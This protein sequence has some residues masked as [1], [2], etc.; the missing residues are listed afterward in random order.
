MVAAR[1]FELGAS[2]RLLDVGA[3]SGATQTRVYNTYFTGQQAL[4]AHEYEKALTR[5]HI[6]LG[7]AAFR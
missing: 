3:G 4:E 7:G 6:A 2:R 1:R 5:L